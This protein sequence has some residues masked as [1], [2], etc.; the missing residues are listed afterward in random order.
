MMN[1]DNE[2][3]LVTVSGP[4]QPGITAQL[5]EIVVNAQ[6]EILDMGQ[7]VTH[8]LLSLSILIG[9]RDNMEREA[10]PILKDLLFAAKKM[11]MGLNFEIVKADAIQ[12]TPGSKFV[13]NCVGQK[14]I[15]P[16]FLRDISQ[17]LA[18][19]KVNILRIDNVNTGRNF[20]SLEITTVTPLDVDANFQEIKAQLLKIGQAH[21]TDMAF[22]K[23]NVYRCSKRLIAFDMD[24]TLIQ[25]EVIDEMAKVHGVAQ[26]VSQVTAA[27]MNGQIDFTQSLTQRVALLKG[28]E[29]A[30]VEQI[31]H[32]L[33]LTLGVPELI[34]TVKEL[35]YKV[36]VISGGFCLFAN[37]LKEQLDLDYAYAN[38]LEVADGKLTGKVVGRVVD[39]EQ[40]AVLL[41][42][43]ACRERINMD[44][45][46]AIGDGANDL[47]MLAKAGLG[48]AFHAKDV[49]RE[50][51]H[52][53]LSFGPMTTILYFLGIP[54]TGANFAKVSPCEWDMMQKG[55]LVT[56]PG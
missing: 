47:P 23:E 24:S 32:A 50:K 44:Q 1:M 13:L 10:P 19:F 54:R 52:N 5:M 36:A 33:P 7:S 30:K 17:M 34:S 35:G 40:K 14:S 22:L 37:S 51:A 45:V 56:P 4:D 25:V 26:E 21:K 39:A 16:A 49:V 38:K 41:E 9:S 29:V 8:G 46:V 18:N 12:I 31:L 11:G 3:I 42:Q 28:L 55:P 53:H 15:S 43:V 27:A 48:I 20:K 2:S 6:Y